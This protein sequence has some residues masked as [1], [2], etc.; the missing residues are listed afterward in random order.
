MNNKEWDITNKPHT[1]NKLDIIRKVFNMWLTVWNC[2]KQQKWVNKEWYVMDLFAGTGLYFDGV[3]KVGGSSLILLENIFNQAD[4]LEKNKIKIKLFL[5]EINKQ[6]FSSLENNIKAFLDTHKKIKNIVEIHFDKKDCNTAINDILKKINDSDK[7]P[8]FILIDP[9][10]LQIKKETI[11]KIADLKNPK[12]I[13]LN[14]ILEGVRRVGGVY[15]K[16]Q[17]GALLNEKEITTIKTFMEFM[18]N[19]VKIIGKT[20]KELLEQYVSVLAEKGL[21]IVGYDMP[22][23]DRNDILYYLLFASKKPKITKSFKIYIIAKKR[24]K[25]RRLLYLVKNMKNLTFLA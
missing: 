20:D 7:N 19:D 16:G 13:L 12:D 24:S 8:L 9:Y 10:G 11:N 1:K 6:N 3:N 17:K 15:K 21:N 22:Y 25:T 14:Y 2:E 18:G 5:V 4:K 23:S